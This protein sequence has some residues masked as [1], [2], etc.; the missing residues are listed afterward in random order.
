MEA[1]IARIESDVEHVKNTMVE[2]KGDL[3]S[4]LLT[5]I[6][7]AVFLLSAFAV[8]YIRLDDKIDRNMVQIDGKLNQLL[9]R[10][11]AAVPVAPA[12]PPQP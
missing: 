2:V 1:R 7:T 11:P 12:K 4:M 3:R 6:G 5:L 9:E 10:L 8:G